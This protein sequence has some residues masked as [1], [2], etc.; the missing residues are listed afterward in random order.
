[1]IVDKIEN[2][3]LYTSLSHALAKAFELLKNEKLINTPDGRYQVDGENL[4]YI[5]QHYI[6]KPLEE[7]KLEAHRKYI[8]VQFI[9]EGEELLGYYP[10]DNLKIATPYDQTKDVAFYNL[11]KKIS[12]ITLEEGMFCILFPN[13]AHL[14]SRQINDPSNVFKVVVKVK[15][16]AK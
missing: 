11:P 3:H 15:I 14:P 12:T 1:M 2:A 4:Y 16:Y 8:D 5:V 9:A 7:G 13:D 6:T 10:L